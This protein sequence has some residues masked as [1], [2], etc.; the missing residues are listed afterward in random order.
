MTRRQRLT[1][2]GIAAVIAIVAVV[3]ILA[4]SGDDEPEQE[5]AATPTATASATE[6][7]TTATAT[8]TATPT[9]KPKPEIPEVRVK[10]GKVVGG[11]AKLRFDEGDRIRFDVTSD[12]D[13]EV[14]VHAYDVYG[15]LVAG[16]PERFSFKATITG[17]I[18]VELHGS[19]LQI[20]ELRIEP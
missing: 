12:I 6:G 10:D 3:V 15:D 16:E 4:T 7:A 20:A 19:G 13:E 14:H 18:E 8:A 5:A 9:P 1:N 2:L 11:V 17:I